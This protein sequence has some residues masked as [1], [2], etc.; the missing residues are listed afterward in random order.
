MTNPAAQ[1]ETVGAMRGQ[2]APG[3]FRW[4]ILGMLFCATSLNY[5]GRFLLGILKPTIMQDLKWTETDNANAAFCFQLA[6]ASGLITERVDLEN[7]PS[8]WGSEPSQSP[9]SFYRTAP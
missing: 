4:V 9:P 8:A 1:P 2:A 3:R 6:Y 7:S 5:M